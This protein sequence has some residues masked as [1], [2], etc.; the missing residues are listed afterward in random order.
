MIN[1]DKN[2]DIK[3]KSINASYPMKLKIYLNKIHIKKGKI[4]YE[5]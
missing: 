3:L 2:L 1:I 5:K 4:K